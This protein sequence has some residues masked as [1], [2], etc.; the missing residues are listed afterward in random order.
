M[1]RSRP[2][3]HTPF[4]TGPA[5]PIQAYAYALITGHTVQ[6]AEQAAGTAGGQPGDMPVIAQMARSAMQAGAAFG[7]RSESAPTG[8]DPSQEQEYEIGTVGASVPGARLYT[9]TVNYEYIPG[10]VMGSTDPQAP[11]WLSVQVDIPLEA[12]IHEAALIMRAAVLEDVE[13]PEA[14][15]PGELLGYSVATIIGH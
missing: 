9:A 4:G 2:Q 13:G 5:R 11:E 14:D 8:A 6:Q 7:Y 10:G 3:Q 1:A 15:Y 12:D